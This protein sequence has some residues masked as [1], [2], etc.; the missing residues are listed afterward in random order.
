MCYNLT[1]EYW[2]IIKHIRKKAAVM[3]KYP[4]YVTLDTNIFVS[5]KFDFGQDSTLGLL[6]KYV[7]SG[8]INV[9]LSNIVIKEVEKHIADEG[10]KICGSTR[11]LRADLL[12]TASE[13]FIK[14]I[15]LDA[16]LQILDKKEIRRKSQA[17]WESYIKLINPEILDNAS[18][19]L[20]MI[21]SDYFNFNPPFENN[22][23]KRKEF[24][25]AFIANQIRKR[26]GKDK[27]V[28]I[29][30]D[31]NGFIRAC[32]SAENHLV[33]K[34]LGDLYDAMNR[35]ETAYQDAVKTIT[36]FM[37]RHIREINTR[38][39]DNDCV[40]VHGM[41]YDK[42]G[43]ADGYDYTETFVSDVRN[44]SY[45]I[46]SID[47]ITE[48]TVRATLVCLSSIDAECYYEDYDNAVWD[49]ETKSYLYLETK[50]ILEKHRTRFFCSVEVNQNDGSVR[51]FPFKVILNGDSL[52]ERLEIKE[53]E[54]D[55][56]D[57]EV[58]GFW[59]LDRYDD[60][61]EEDLSESTFK[62]RIIDLFNKINS[63]YDEYEETAAVYDDL[64]TAIKNGDASE[65]IKI[66]STNIDREIKFPYPADLDEI[67]DEEVEKVLLWAE[68][69]YDRLSELSEN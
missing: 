54:N 63:L 49:S 60:F 42:D 13:E 28:A 51:I 5:N 2:F 36:S 1:C 31:D 35:E 57:R 64:I 26:F 21:I 45:K 38:I 15:G 52:I 32:G 29:I 53:Y 50:K 34:S 7:E 10:D 14:Q 56:Q 17:E 37:V 47:E 9:V 8:K 40:E 22:D 3:I 65:I 4:L 16:L 66:L 24:P 58:F 68:Q 55:Y 20:D 6:A 46:G 18:I 69:T 48:T 27:L 67:S 41:S 25:D 23:K 12:K 59:P 61:L 19:N 62:S 11:K 44:T 30:S 39:E 33:Y 43:I